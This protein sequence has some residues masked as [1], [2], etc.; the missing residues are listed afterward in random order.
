MLPGIENR[1]IKDSEYRRISEIGGELQ[2]LNLDIVALQETRIEDMGKLQE[3]NFT[4]FWKGLPPGERRIH[5][6]GF[7][8]IPLLVQLAHLLVTLSV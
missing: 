3:K 7:S 2:R 1:D 4:F 6:V 5:G 8:L